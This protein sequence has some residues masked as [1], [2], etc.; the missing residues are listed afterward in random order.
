MTTNE[1]IAWFSCYCLVAG[2]YFLIVVAILGKCKA[3]LVS[4]TILLVL[5]FFPSRYVD[6]K[7]LFNFHISQQIP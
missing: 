2:G 7:P 1:C 5:L 4:S 6:R 3:V